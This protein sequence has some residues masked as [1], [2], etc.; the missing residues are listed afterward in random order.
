VN[1]DGNVIP[2]GNET[3]F[4]EHANIR[5]VSD[6]TMAGTSV[7]LLVKDDETNQE[8]II[9]VT[10]AT[11]HLDMDSEKLTPV[12][13]LT[14]ALAM[15]DATVPIEFVQMVKAGP[16]LIIEEAPWW[17]RLWHKLR[18]PVFV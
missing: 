10:G 3:Y 12:L 6:G 16:M 2:L 4:R 9:P 15:I 7:R 17:E 8:S 18:G 11:W 14:V 5:L 1:D 13:H